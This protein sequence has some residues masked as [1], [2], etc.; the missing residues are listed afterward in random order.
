MYT[1]PTN[2]TYTFMFLKVLKALREGSVQLIPG[3]G[4]GIFLLV[5]FTV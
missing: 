4:G 5:L 3:E 1:K 2:K